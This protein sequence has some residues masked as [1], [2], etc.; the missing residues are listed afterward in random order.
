MRRLK[1]EL[2]RE[3]VKSSQSMKQLN[4]AYLV[5]IQQLEQEASRVERELHKTQRALAKQHSN[6]TNDS[7]DDRELVKL[8]E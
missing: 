7:Q 5:K 3:L 6:Q 8:V 4:G 1:E 2:I